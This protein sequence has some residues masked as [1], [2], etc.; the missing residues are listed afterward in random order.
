[1]A[2]GHGRRCR[3]TRLAIAVAIATATAGAAGAA[4]LRLADGSDSLGLKVNPASPIGDRLDAAPPQPS[5]EAERPFAV[6]G[7]P[8]RSCPLRSIPYFADIPSSWQ[9][10]Q[11]EQ[12]AE[13]QAARAAGRDREWGEGEKRKSYSSRRSKSSASTRCSIFLNRANFGAAITA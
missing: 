3:L 13:K 6:P 7:Q 11:A 8:S 5:V 4:E 1:M 10:A 2:T 12:K 9:A